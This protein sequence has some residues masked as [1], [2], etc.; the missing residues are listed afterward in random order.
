MTRRNW[1]PGARG[2]LKPEV[3]GRHVRQWPG[4]VSSRVYR[5][6]LDRRSARDDEGTWLMTAHPASDFDPDD[7]VEILQVLPAEYHAQFLAEYE[8]AV[9]RARRP[10]Q[11]RRLHDLLRLWRLRA[12]AYS[13]PGYDA[14]MEA[15]SH[16]R[17]DFAL[18]QQVIPGWPRR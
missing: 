4:V 7:P 1:W 9:D 12:I 6:N 15:A 11:F 10:E 16:G 3:A 2:I 14:R 17:A 5:K 13:D 8:T 18:A